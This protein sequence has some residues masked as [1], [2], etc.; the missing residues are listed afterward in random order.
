MNALAKIKKFVK[1]EKREAKP[2]KPSEKPATKPAKKVKPPTFGEVFT[3][4]SLAF[5]EGIGKRAVRAFELDRAILRAGLSTHPVKY[6][7]IIIAA[8]LLAAIFSI[9]TVVAT[10]IFISPPI[11]TMVILSLALGIAPIIVFSIGLGYPSL[12]ASL[13]RNSVENEL[14]FFMAY[15]SS[16]AISG[17]S[18]ERVIERAANLRVFRAIREEARRI[19]TRMRMFGEDPVTALSNVAMEHP[20]SR[21][22]DIMLGYAT[23]VRTG[24]DVVH[25]LEIRTRELF[26]ARTNEIRNIL[27]RLA[28]F[29]EIYTIFGVIISI[30]LFVFFAVQGAMTAAQQMRQGVAI[31]FDITTP[32]LYNFVALPSL[33]FAIMFAIHLNQPKNPVSYNLA[34]AVLLTFLPVSVAVFILVLIVS[35]GLGVFSGSIG[36]NEVRALIIST[37]AALLTISIP[38]WIKYRS[39]VRGHKG[40]VKATADFLR[41]LSEARKTGLSPEKCIVMLSQRSYR[42][43]TPVVTRAAAALSIG[44]SLENALRRALRGVREWFTIASFR[45]LADS[46]VFGGGSPDVIDTLAR[47]TQSLSELEE[48]TRR[49]MRSQV[50]LPYFGAVMLTTMPVI[51][52][53]ML[54][55][56]ANISIASA[57]PLILV[58]LLGAI[59]NSFIMGLIAGKASEATLAAGFKHATILV[60]VSA[61]SSLATLIYLAT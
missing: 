53:Y 10:A 2:E 32:M 36:L 27:N 17:Q 49:R 39:I 37:T 8:T 3:A 48:E 40:L 26:E 9:A 24:G 45:F 47:F 35:G 5:F 42:N 61:I 28:S 44:Y 30:T 22:R 14:P 18:L 25:Y 31:S 34:Y 12:K 58:M 52:L 55:K 60:L 20:S 7:S 33:G 56:L 19:M 4:F 41:D 11:V 51:I 50:I 38:T 15:A 13:R 54:L 16:M 57:A 59:L 23:A 46:I 29:L 1:R 43:L 6:A 21:F